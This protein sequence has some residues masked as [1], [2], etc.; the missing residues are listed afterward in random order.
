MLHRVAITGLG[1]VSSIGTSVSE[2]TD[3]LYHGR[4]GI[5][6][7]PVRQD[8][9]FNSPLTGAIKNF[10]PRFPLNRKQRKTTPQFVEWAAEAAFCALDDSGLSPDDIRNDR[11][12]LIFGCDSSVL[13]GIE[14]AN[15]LEEV[16]DTSRLG[17]GLVFQSMTSTTTINLNA[18][19]GTQGA[20]WS[21]SGACASSGHAVGQ[22][23]D[24]IMLGRQDRIICGGAQEINWQATCSFDGLGAFSTRVDSPQSASRPFAK[25]RDGLVPGGGAAVLMLERYDLAVARRAPIWGEI[26]G[27]GFSSDGENIVAPSRTGLGRAM[28]MALKNAELMPQDISYLC[29]HA[30]STPLGDAMEAGNILDIFGERG[31]PVSST[32]SMTGH[33]LW[34]SGAAQVVYSCLM[35]RNDFMAANINFDGG[36]EA[37]SHLDIITETRQQPLTSALCNSAGFGGTN[38][39]LVI[40]F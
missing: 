12:G 29:A 3:A 22:A 30:T 5:V 32:K 8:L 2:V 40:G 17:S 34:M 37:T 20:S 4:S 7:D 27:Y 11:S 10:S 31:V 14:Q 25:S 1:I 38:S 24:L 26:L 33:E 39:S 21:I 36:D 35:A 13:A 28:R 23:A 16:R 6:I 9:G 18:I 19:L 15:R